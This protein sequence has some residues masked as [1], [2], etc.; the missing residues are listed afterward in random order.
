[1]EGMSTQ[2]ILNG[3]DLSTAN[4]DDLLAAMKAEEKPATPVAEA[5]VQ[6]MPKS[7][8]KKA[9]LE[10]IADIP[11][12]EAMLAGKETFED[13]D[14]VADKSLEAMSDMP[15]DEHPGENLDAILNA[16]VE[17]LAENTNGAAEVPVA[18]AMPEMPAA[19]APAAEAPAA[20]AMPEMAATEA[21]SEM[22]AM[23]AA[24]LA[25]EAAPAAEAPVAEAMPEMPAAEAPV[26]EAMPEMPAAEVPAAEA[27]PEMPEAETAAL[28]EGP[29]E[30]DAMM[31]AM[32]A[33]EAAPAAEAPVAEAM[34]EMP[35]AEVS[36]AEAI[37]EM[38]AAEALT[39]EEVPTIEE[40]MS[41]MAIEEP[42]IEETPIEEMAL[43]EEMPAEEETTNMEVMRGEMSEV[44]EE[45]VEGGAT[46]EEPVID[47][48]ESEQTPSEMDMG[49]A[50]D[51]MEGAV[52]DIEEFLNSEDYEYITVQDG[53]VTNIIIK[54]S[55]G[56]S[57]AISYEE[58]EFDSFEA[59][60]CKDGKTSYK[61]I[62]NEN[63]REAVKSGGNKA[64]TRHKG[65]KV[66]AK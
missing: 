2:D 10:P 66:V 46:A 56:N 54:T 16:E 43:T 18:E 44:T 41:D 48:T 52:E 40:A 4:V 59:C 15:I 53:S 47:T 24:M 33:G 1:M 23:M 21:P 39:A 34:P 29:S 26:A 57:M 30:M 17:A 32:L 12:L 9:E 25:G 5:S 50:S 37:P 20:E 13:S 58:N 7:S 62:M 6:E 14:F 19:E 31:A 45:S 65:S 36:A 27:M 3:Q 63:V 35:A 28:E 60:Y 42:Q 55:D 64:I 22:D 11:D 8:R 49:A 51:A 38:P 61:E